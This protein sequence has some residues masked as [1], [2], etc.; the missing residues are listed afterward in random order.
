EL[1]SWLGCRSLWLRVGRSKALRQAVRK[2]LEGGHGRRRVVWSAVLEPVFQPADRAQGERLGGGAEQRV[3]Q[4][5]AGQA[6]GA[7]E[8]GAGGGRRPG[9]LVLLGRR[10]SRR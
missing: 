9:G 4:P 6:G 10:P 1:S 5:D 2:A 7:G 8:G 3:E